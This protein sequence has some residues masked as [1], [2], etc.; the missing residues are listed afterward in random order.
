MFPY[1]PL[2]PV[3]E[4]AMYSAQAV[5]PVVYQEMP[6]AALPLLLICNCGDT[7]DWV[8]I[9]GADIE[10]VKA[11]PANDNFVPSATVMFAVPSNATP[12][13]VRD[14]AS[15]VAVAALPVIDAE[16]VMNPRGF[17]ALYGVNVRA[18]VT[19]SKVSVIGPVR[20]LKLGTLPPAL[21]AAVAALA[22]ALVAATSAAVL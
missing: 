8:L 19:S 1:G 14:V 15:F 16:A 2:P 3:P 4:F 20:V 6:D 9:P 21:A 22:A 12:L 7:I 10:P 13:I 5:Q 11:P 17:I 18:A